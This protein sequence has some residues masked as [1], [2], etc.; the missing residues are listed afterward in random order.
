VNNRSVKLA[1]G[2]LMLCPKC[3]AARFPPKQA[4]NDFELAGRSD[5]ARASAKAKSKPKQLSSASANG[6]SNVTD[7][8]D[9]AHCDNNHIIGHTNSTSPVNN[10]MDDQV[11]LLRAE[12][13]HQRDLVLKLQQQLRY[14]LS[15]LG[16]IEQDIQLTFNDYSEQTNNMPACQVGVADQPANQ[17]SQTDADA[18]IQC[19]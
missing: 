6:K 3:E 19:P 11:S 5:N 9:S 13:H 16:V 7:A 18:N 17:P 4:G 1:Q 2:D 14:V 8:V 12:V 10:V 15:F